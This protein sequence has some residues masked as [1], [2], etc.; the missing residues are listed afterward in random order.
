MTISTVAEYQKHTTSQTREK[1]FSKWIKET[2][3]HDREYTR[4]KKLCSETAGIPPAILHF[5]S[6]Y[7]FQFSARRIA[8]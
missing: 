2:A 3:A 1:V 7:L 8:I 4:L 6:K 5:Y